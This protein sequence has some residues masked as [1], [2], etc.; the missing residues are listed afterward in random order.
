MDYEELN[1]LIGRLKES[2]EDCDP[3]KG[4]WK[5]LWNLAKEIGAGFKETR[6]PTKDE[7]DQAWKE[8][9]LLREQARRR[10]EESRARFEKQ[11]EEWQQREQLSSRLRAKVQ[12]E[13]IQSHPSTGIVRAIGD[14]ILLPLL[15]IETMLRQILGLE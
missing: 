9:E 1:N 13:A 15:M 14:I 2:V 10:S 5:E 6:Y 3:K 7:K 12:C 4:Y 8:F 11:Q